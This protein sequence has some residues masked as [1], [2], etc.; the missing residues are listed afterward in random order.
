MRSFL[1]QFGLIVL[2]TIISAPA[3]A[4]TVQSPAGLQDGLR[5]GDAI[6]VT[7]WRQPDLSG[8]FAISDDGTVSHP[9]YK[10]V[11]VRGLS[12]GEVESRI[13]ALLARFDTN[14]QFVVEPLLRV[15]VGG[16]VR[17]PNLYKLSPEMTVAEAVGIAGGITDQG[18]LQSVHLF[19]DGAEAVVNL[20]EPQRGM[21]L[22]RIQSGDQIF[23]DRK[24]SIFREYI[25]PAGS[26]TAAFAA[27]IGL[28]IRN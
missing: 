3:L 17:Q 1:A 19:R 22:S 24:V 7:V 9:M 21:A 18:K 8:E 20:A 23:V 26:I 14:P 16:Q 5:P 27:I 28:I 13:R 6:R 4:Q 2:A 25:A 11:N 12:I 15:L 10:A